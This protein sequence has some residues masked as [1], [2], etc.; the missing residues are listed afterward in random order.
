[1]VSDGVLYESEVDRASRERAFQ[2]N[3]AE[4]EED[5]KTIWGSCSVVERVPGKCAGRWVFKDIRLP[6][7]ML[8][9]HLAEGGTIDSFCEKHNTENHR[10]TVQQLLLH[11]QDKLEE[12]CRY[13]YAYT[14]RDIITQVNEHPHGSPVYL[15][16]MEAADIINKAKEA[17]DAKTVW[18]GCSVIGREI[19]KCSGRWIFAPVRFPIYLLFGYLSAGYNIEDFYEQYHIEPEKSKQLLDHLARKLEEDRRH[20]YAY[21]I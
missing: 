12:D 8:F 14:S 3:R 9:G 6:L 19:G 15:A 1:M 16:A 21:T 4:E 17:E 18:G 13:D 7:W 5:A 2:I 20:N 11:M 10:G